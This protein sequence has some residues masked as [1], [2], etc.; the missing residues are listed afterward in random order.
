M[1]KLS[2]NTVVDQ[3]PHNLEIEI[4]LKLIH[5][6]ASNSATSLTKKA[7]SLIWDELIKNSPILG[8]H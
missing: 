5:Y 2:E 3:L 4:R 8:D 1:P 7:L 6:I